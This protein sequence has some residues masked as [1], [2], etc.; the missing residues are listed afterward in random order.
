MDRCQNSLLLVASLIFFH[1]QFLS[2]KKSGFFKIYVLCS[3]GSVSKG[4]ALKTIKLKSST[5]KKFYNTFF[6]RGEE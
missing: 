1:L 5:G 3:S 4:M 2:F 6:H